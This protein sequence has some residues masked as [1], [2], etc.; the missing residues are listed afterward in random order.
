VDG[1]VL[2]RTIDV[3]AEDEQDVADAVGLCPVSAIF[4]ERVSE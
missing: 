1:A 3:R 2:L 4:M